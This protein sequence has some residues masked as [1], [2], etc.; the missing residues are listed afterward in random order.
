MQLATKGGPPRRGLADQEISSGHPVFFVAV[1]GLANQ[2]P[3]G[4]RAGS[5]GAKTATLV[6][7]HKSTKQGRGQGPALRHLEWHV[8]S[9][10]G[11]GMS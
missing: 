6:E 1:C 9:Q 3:M 2:A 5:P 4:Q 7:L 8:P 10:R 11:L